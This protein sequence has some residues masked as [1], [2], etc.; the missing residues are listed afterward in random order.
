MFL[1]LVIMCFSTWLAAE[2]LEE[3]ERLLHQVLVSHTTFPL[4]AFFPAVTRHLFRNRWKA[5]VA[6]HRRGRRS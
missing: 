5:N 1:F 4:F 3:I 6:V 2:A